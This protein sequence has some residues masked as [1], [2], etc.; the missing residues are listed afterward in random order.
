MENSKGNE[1]GYSEECRDFYLAALRLCSFKLEKISNETV[2]KLHELKTK[3][4]FGEKEE[5]KSNEPKTPEKSNP[6]EE[7]RRLNSAKNWSETP[8]FRLSL[9]SNFPPEMPPV[10]CLKGLIGNCSKPFEKQLTES[11]VKSNQCRLSLNKIDVQNAVNPLLKEE[12]DPTEGIPVKV[13]DSNGKEYPMTFITWCSKIHVLKEGWINFCN[14]HGLVAYQDFVTL[15]V[16]RN[17]KTGGL[18]FVITSRR[19]EVFE[20]IKRRKLN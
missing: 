7:I 13:Y 11:D 2:K 4:S 12:D 3:Y 9:S 15:W 14:D 20:A 18:C 17:K 10:A 8:K 6:A 1:D 16:F 19:L 5:A